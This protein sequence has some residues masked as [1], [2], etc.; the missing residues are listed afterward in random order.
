MAEIA[1]VTQRGKYEPFELQVARGQIAWHSVVHV[2]GY[3]PDVDTSEETVWPDGGTTPVPPAATVMKV[4]SSSASDASAGTGART[5][6]IQGLDSVHNVI[7]EVVTLNGQTTVLTTKQF[8]HINYIT[9]MTVGSGG[10]NAGI[11]YVGDGVVTAGVPA[12]IY[13]IVNTAFN[14]STTAFYTI[15]AGYTGYIRSGSISAGQDGGTAQ[16]TGYLVTRGQDN[17]ARV[18]AVA[19]LNNG[20]SI[21]DFTFPIY[22]PEKTSIEARAVGSSN[23]NSVSANF[24]ILLIKNDGA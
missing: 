23:N 20:Q 6:L 9:V 16:V 15:P 12:T 3:N 13:G 11:I 24:Q 10:K 14:A 22:I 1:S 17:V 21:Y 18:A 19:T 2:W 4:T 7:S 5:V 8:L